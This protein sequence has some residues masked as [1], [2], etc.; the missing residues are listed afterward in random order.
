MVGSLIA[1]VSP[2][3]L[4]LF[5]C[6]NFCN[7]FGVVFLPLGDYDNVFASFSSDFPSNSKM[8]G[9]SYHTAFD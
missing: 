4:D 6:F 3:L 2:A 9:P 7:C 1:I 8:G 5:L